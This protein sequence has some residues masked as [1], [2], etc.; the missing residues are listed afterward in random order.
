VSSP[1]SA[2]RHRGHRGEPGSDF[3]E[4]PDPYSIDH[5]D[6]EVKGVKNVSEKMSNLGISAG[7]LLSVPL[8]AL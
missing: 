3:L 8:G 5:F 6:A 2:G 1:F 7:L 4:E